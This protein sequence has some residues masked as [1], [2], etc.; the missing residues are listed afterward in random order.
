MSKRVR[1]EPVSRIAARI[2]SQS[3]ESELYKQ[4][5]LGELP[6]VA[7]LAQRHGLGAHMTHALWAIS[8]PD[9]LALVSAQER[10]T[11]AQAD[12]KINQIANMLRESYGV[13]P[14][15]G[16][17]LCMDNRPDYLLSWTALFR[18]GARGVH[19]SPKSSEDELTY[20]ATH[21]GAKVIIA[22]E[23]TSAAAIQLAAKHE[24]IISLIISDP[25]GATAAAGPY[26]TLD[27]LCSGVSAVM[28]RKQSRSTPSDNV[29]YTS[30]TTG[31]P[32]GAVR[33]MTGFGLKELTRILER[34]PLRAGERHLIVCPLY[35]SGAQVFALL[36]TALGAT[37]YLEPHFDAAKTVEA[38][39]RHA[40]HSIFVGPTMI[41]R[42]VNLPD[43]HFKRHPM[44]ALRVMISGAAP[45]AQ[46]LRE[47]AM[48]RFGAQV[49]YDFYGATEMGWVTVIG[50]DELR[51]KPGS[52]GRALSGQRVSIIDEQGQELPRGQTGLIYVENE[53]V[54]TGYLNNPQATEQ[55]RRGHGL[56]VEDLGHMDEDGY[57]YVDGRARD[58]I[59]SGGVNL[60]PVEI[61][62]ALAMDPQVEEVAVVG[63]P[64]EEWGERVVAVVVVRPGERFDQAQAIAL[65]KQRLA[66]YKVPKQWEVVE[67]LPRNPTGKVLK[68]ELRE[69]FKGKERR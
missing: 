53:Q 9:R 48:A 62:E 67:V 66:S 59:I 52:V 34:L 2:V 36:M 56:T 39:S 8:C 47:R 65:A 28:P 63:L 27:R 20:L 10:Y 13:G 15:D 68:R 69:R 46:A 51:L 3:V 22:G 49:I 32:K 31:K 12:A 54:M 19:A 29:V 40:I 33:N 16:V 58:M 17:V 44:P 55:T 21:S 64:D 43:D 42:M 25:S 37:L 11:Y 50:G 14:G 5:P 45:F 6:A 26:P 23:S 57:L 1:L 60:Y 4:V 30:G 41:H 35:H 61:E 7:K 18:L 24:G 38:L